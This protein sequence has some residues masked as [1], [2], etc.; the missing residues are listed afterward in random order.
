[1]DQHSDWGYVGKGSARAYKEKK[2]NRYSK[3][4]ARLSRGDSDVVTSGTCQF[5]KITFMLFSKKQTNA[6]ITKQKKAERENKI[7]LGAHSRHELIAEA[8]YT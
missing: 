8:I 5:M 3:E 4:I 1:M 6:Y 2:Y 7:D